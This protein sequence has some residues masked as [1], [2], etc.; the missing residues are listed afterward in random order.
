MAIGNS[1]IP[2]GRAN[3]SPLK[4]KIHLSRNPS[5][6]KK[7]PIWRTFLLKVTLMCIFTL[8][9]LMEPAVLEV[10]QHSVGEDVCSSPAPARKFEYDSRYCGWWIWALLSMNLYCWLIWE[11]CVQWC[12]KSASQPLVAYTHTH[13]LQVSS[14]FSTSLRQRLCSPSIRSLFI[15]LYN[16]GLKCVICHLRLLSWNF[17]FNLSKFVSDNFCFSNKSLSRNANI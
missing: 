3:L 13:T 2:E 9:E 6:K 17:F 8:C 10:T 12:H 7:T 5:P 15:L 1:W 11:E 14:F 16:L 4:L